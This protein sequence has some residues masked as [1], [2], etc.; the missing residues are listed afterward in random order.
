MD[1]FLHM[2]TSTSQIKDRTFPAP[3]MPPCAPPSQDLLINLLSMVNF[4][5]QIK[6]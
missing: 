4:K 1:G 2:W 5:D 6:D 3:K